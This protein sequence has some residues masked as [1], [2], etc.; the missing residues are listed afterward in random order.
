MASLFLHRWSL[1]TSLFQGLVILFGVLLADHSWAQEQCYQW[2]VRS[3]LPWESSQEAACATF[4]AWCES[5]PPG[6][7]GVCVPSRENDTYVYGNEYGGMGR[8]D[9]RPFPDDVYCLILHYRIRKETGNK[10]ITGSTAYSPSYQQVECDEPPECDG[11]ID[12][13]EFQY[14]YT[15]GFSPPSAMCDADTNCKYQRTGSVDICLG[16]R[17]AA[18]YLGT[19][20]T[21]SS[22]SPP[23]DPL[24]EL[25]AEDGDTCIQGSGGDEF[26]SPNWPNK[27]NCGFLN[28]EWICLSAVEDDGCAALPSGGRVCGSEAPVPPV[29]DNGTAGV[30]A[31]P[32][33]QITVNEVDTY[34]Y[35]NSSTVS[36]SSRPA[37]TDN[38]YDGDDDGDGAGKLKKGDGDGSIG[39]G[40]MCDPETD[41]GCNPDGDGAPDITAGWQ[42]WAE[43]EGVFDA[44]AGCFATATQGMWNTLSDQS[45]LIGV[46]DESI[47]AWPSGGGSCPSAVVELAG[48]NFDFWEVPCMFLEDVEN[49][50]SVLF[51][52]LWSFIGLRILLDIPGGE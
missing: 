25:G 6:F 28:D 16:D 48:E 52:L 5:Q 27:N 23:D 35:Y 39:E 30:P 19:G 50:L 21:C 31:E 36:N 7:G 2:R 4:G 46:I 1:R 32:D 9:G 42:C 15:Y 8:W 29:P 26:C 40:L 44:V 12:G 14:Q 49:V 38:P 11:S 37:G 3:H 17:C 51:M 22:E 13:R 20:E 41:S 18:S 43:G 33:L 10:E 34:N 47:D 24:D 45:A